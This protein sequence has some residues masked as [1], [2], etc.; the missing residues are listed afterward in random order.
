MQYHLCPG[1]SRARWWRLTLGL[2]MPFATVLW[3]F[4]SVQ[5]PIPVVSSVNDQCAEKLF[6]YNNPNNY[7]EVLSEES[8]HYVGSAKF[9]NKIAEADAQWKDRSIQHT[10]RFGAIH[11]YLERLLKSSTDRETKVLELGFGA[12]TNMI[13]AHELL[14]H[15]GEIWGIE[16]TR[17]WVEHA[18]A[19]FD[20][21]GLRFVQGD[22]TRAEEYL[23]S[24]I[25]FD[26]IF[27]ADVWEHIPP[28]RLGY[29]WNNISKL[30]KRT[31]KLYIHIPNEAKQR[32]E[33][34]I[35]GGQFFEE[36]VLVEDLLK[37]AR[38]FGMTLQELGTDDNSE[39]SYISLVFRFQR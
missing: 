39:H 23:P 38:C 24:G 27:L 6:T 4:R 32:A 25:Q 17:G 20:E 28:Y 36:V 26:V 9:T 35:G 19:N 13:V 12:G 16:L 22:I 29:L 33:Q 31:G 14:K 18:L 21:A 11:Q 15:D 5:P 8:V 10:G 2:G 1:L 30:L 34:T 7:D 3:L 37:Q